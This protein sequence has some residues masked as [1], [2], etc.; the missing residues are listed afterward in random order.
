MAGTEAQDLVADRRD[1]RD[2]Q[3]AAADHD[4]RVLPADQREGD[5]RQQD[6]HDQELG[7]A[8]LVGGRVLADLGDRERITG[9]EGVDRHVLGAV[10]LEDA[11]DVGGA[12]DQ[13]QVA[14]EDADPDQ[15]LDE[16]LDQ[17]V[18][19]VRRGDRGDQ[20]GQQEED[21]DAGHQGHAEHQR[22]GAAAELDA[23]LLGLDVGAAH[24]PARPDD[25][26]LVEDD[27]AAH[28]RPLR[29]A[30]AV[31]ARVEALGGVHDL[32]VRMAQGHGDRVATAHQ[33]ALDE[34]L[35]AVG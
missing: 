18:L 12:P 7:T 15:P 1:H 4:Q 22:D 29:P 31:E 8:A 24:E 33:D 25:E 27:Q 28:Q 3:D 13:D 30:G 17:A 34:R 6:D 23:V 21:A 5:D 2:Q 14:E 35:A 9:L 10:V 16:V 19:D 26:R 32:A 20:Q 11:A